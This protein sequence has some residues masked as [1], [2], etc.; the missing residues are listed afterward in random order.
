[1]HTVIEKVLG[2]V[3]VGAVVMFGVWV[4]YL[5]LTSVAS[6]R[7]LIR[8]D[9]FIEYASSILW[10]LA[11]ICL[12]VAMVYAKRRGTRLWPYWILLLFFI[13]CGG[14]EISWG[15]RIFN[16]ET[17]EALKAVN[18]QDETNVHNIGSISIFSNSFFLVALGFF[19]VLPY[20]AKRKP[21]VGQFLEKR[22]FPLPGRFAVYIFV[23]SIV[24]WLIIGIRFGTLGFHPF[25]IYPEHYYNQSDDEIFEPLAAYS[26][27]AFSI[28]E[29]MRLR[30]KT[31]VA[32]ARAAPETKVI[33]NKV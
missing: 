1:V 29:A 27:F 30:G 7:N 11:A 24:I 15:Q 2:R 4:I 8:E 26:F 5:S 20:L 19:F 17:P 21:T 28:F 10:F 31:G 23:I 14:E 12:L 18:V 16:I 3:L 9:R 13:A 6:Y 32:T 33:N 25:S 22:S